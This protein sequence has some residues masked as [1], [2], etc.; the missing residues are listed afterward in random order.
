M[1]DRKFGIETLCL[2]A[3]PGAGSGHR[4][5]RRADLPDHVVR[6]RFGRARRQPVQPA[7]L[8]QRLLAAVES[9]RGGAGGADGRDRRRPRG[10]RDRER[11]G[12]RNGGDADAAEGRRPLRRRQHAL[13]RHL[14]AVR[15]DLQAD[16][17]RLQL[18]RTR[19]TAQFP[20]GLAAQQQGRLRRDGRQSATQRHRLRGGRGDRARPRHSAGGRQ[21]ARVALP[22]PADPARRRHRRPFGHQVPRRARHHHGRRADRIR[23]VSLGQRQ[24]PGDGRAFARLSRRA[25]LRNLRRLRL[26]DEGAHGNGAHARSDAGADVGLDAAAGDRDAAG[27]HGA[28]RGQ[29]HPRRRVPFLAS[30]GGLGQ[31]PRARPRSEPQP[32]PRTVPALHAEGG[33]RHPRVRPASPAPTAMPRLPASASSTR[34]AS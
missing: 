22:V 21:H 2:H 12:G 31:L 15:R 33:R 7:D 1:A 18:R 3:G 4:L 27:P 11:H 20:G 14:L 16:G 19:R 34:P 10:A 23:E 30:A 24:L 9:D 8:R 26:H 32:L 5:A 13:R 29:R 17:H 28:S 25:L 6:L